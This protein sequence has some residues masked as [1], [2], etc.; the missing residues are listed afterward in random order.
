MLSG[1]VA[2]KR[3]FNL[4]GLLFFQGLINLVCLAQTLNA[5]LSKSFALSQRAL[6]VL[7][8]AVTP[9]CHSM[10]FR[11][12]RSGNHFR[13]YPAA[14]FECCS[15]RLTSWRLTISNTLDSFFHILVVCF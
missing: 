12:S 11:D 1:H 4:A 3:L 13:F 6:S 8:Q 5:Q 7:E 10:A 9:E 14:S 2:I 15:I